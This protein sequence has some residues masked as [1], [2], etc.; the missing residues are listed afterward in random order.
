MRNKHRVRNTFIGA[1]VGGGI[2]AGIGAATGGPCGCSFYLT[3]PSQ[4]AV[5]AAPG[6]VIGAAV[7][8]LWPTHE[9][10]YRADGAL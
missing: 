8:A 10:I 2:G 9:V 4:A 3:R 5:F 7:G 1:G 6:I